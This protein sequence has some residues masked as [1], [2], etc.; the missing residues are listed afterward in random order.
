[1]EHPLAGGRK[2]TSSL[3]CCSG[4]FAA[5]GGECPGR[6]DSVREGGRE[7]EEDALIVDGGYC[8]SGSLVGLLLWDEVIFGGGYYWLRFYHICF[9]GFWFAWSFGGVAVTFVD[10]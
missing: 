8:W 6:G 10:I 2:G 5:G 4:G 3:S 1:M 9:F 7:G